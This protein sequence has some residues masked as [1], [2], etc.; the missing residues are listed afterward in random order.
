MARLKNFHRVTGASSAALHPAVSFRGGEAMIERIFS[1]RGFRLL[2]LGALLFAAPVQSQAW[3][4]EDCM[5]CHGDKD[6]VPEDRPGLFVDITHFED[7]NASHAGMNC[8]DCHSDIVDLPHEEKLA[9]V[10]C[11]ECHDDVQEI[12]DR[13][14]HGRLRDHPS[15]GEP[16][17]CV[18]C[19]GSHEIYP[20]DDPRSK[21]HHHNLSQTCVQCHEDQALQEAH[22]SSED[23]GAMQSYILSVHGHANV[24]DP[25]SKAA[26]CSDCHGWHDTQSH[27]SPDST[28]NRRNVARTCGQ[29]HEDVLT[30]FYESVHGNLVREGNPDAPVC[31]DC[32]GEHTI[33]SPTDRQSTVS[34]FQI[35]E[36]CGKCHDDQ[37]IIDK[38]KIPI[39][40]PSQMYEHS[41]HGKALLV[42]QNEKAAA[43]QDC[44]G[45]HSIL[46]G[47]HPDSKVNRLHISETC[48]QCHGDIREVYDRSVHGQATEKGVRESPVCTDC[49]G[50]HNILSHLDPESP[51]YPLRLAKE[52]CARCHDSLVVNRK[53]GLPTEQVSSYFESYHGLASRLG[54]TNSA[55]CAS[56]H[57]VH[58]ILSHTDPQSSIHPSNLVK[59][60]GQCHPAA[61]EQFVAGLVHVSASNPENW[62]IYWVRKI[63]IALIVVTIGGMLI[64]NLLIVFRHI[65]DKYRRQKGIPR[66]QRFPGAALVQHILLS[67]F[68][69]MLVVTGFSLSFPESIFTRM[70]TVYLG[71]GEE[72]RSLVHRVCAVGL[73][74][75]TVWHLLSITLT[76]RGREELRALALKTRDLRD[77]FQNVMYHIGLAKTKP[78]FDRFDYS[79]KMEYWAFMWGTLVMILTGLLMWFPAQAAQFMGMERIWVDV[80]S[81]IHYYEAWL[82]TL[83]ILIWHF[84][85]VVFHPEEYPMAMSWVTGELSVESM[86]ER[87]PEEL[88]RLIKEGKIKPPEPAE[89]GDSPHSGH[90]T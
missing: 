54:D 81:V 63:Y 22:V 55:N 50:E 7:E 71:L 19:H 4:N 37:A 58:D 44:H 77:A 52:V 84:F 16:A 79:E 72:D 40:S 53:Y 59:T 35:S 3:E 89:G 87:H 65:R 6:E 21:V 66:V 60:C 45:H 17:T 43:C 1:S 90:T 85:F 86:E 56:C 10:N 25:T 29:C 70:M 20:T 73:I 27:D 5:L 64:H 74:F 76:R 31:T 82:A 12:Y 23:R 39:S 33:Q 83:A 28:V 38:Y 18:S 36:T 8:V 42:D 47:S 11:A 67:I 32:H 24:D 46:G 2:F 26:T 57:G 78:K 9:P 68:F 49:H 41:V 88:E 80:A 75:T 61:S 34:K 15:A 30:E 51:V 48:G 62:L 14:I 69:I 13:S